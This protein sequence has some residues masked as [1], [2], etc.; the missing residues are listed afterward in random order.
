MSCDAK[1]NICL[2]SEATLFRLDSL[3]TKSMTTYAVMAGTGYLYDMLFEPLKRVCVL[4]EIEDIDLVA[5]KENPS[6]TAPLRT[7]E[8][9]MEYIFDAL[10]GSLDKVPV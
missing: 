8:L 3:F 10:D 5:L 6:K 9:C 2:E 1:A 4:A 7:M